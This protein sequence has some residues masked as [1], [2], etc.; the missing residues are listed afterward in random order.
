MKKTLW[1]LLDDRKGSVGQAKG[2]VEALSGRMN[3][4]EKVWKNSL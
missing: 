2:I 1:V 3:I 4:V